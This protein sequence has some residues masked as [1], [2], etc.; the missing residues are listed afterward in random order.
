M[1]KIGDKAP[2]NINVLDQNGKEISLSKLVGRPA[3]IYFYPKD[4]TP[5]CTKEAC[6]YRDFNNEL[7]KLGVQVIGVSA[8]SPKSHQNFAQKHNLNFD[9]WSDKNRELISAFG[10][11]GQK[12]MFGKVYMGILRIT[13][14]IDKAG[15]IIMVWPKVDATKNASE[16]LDFF[17]S[18]S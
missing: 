12:S 17:K 18:L 13:F 14:A 2:L 11:V 15:K 7:T 16:V 6:S 3:V 9:L 4:N 5:G 10:A 8:D 1:L